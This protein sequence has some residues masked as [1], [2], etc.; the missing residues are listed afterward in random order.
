MCQD[1][2]QLKAGRLFPGTN[3]SDYGLISILERDTIYYADEILFWRSYSS[4]SAG[5]AALFSSA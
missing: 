4:I 2:L 5:L 3:S 1:K